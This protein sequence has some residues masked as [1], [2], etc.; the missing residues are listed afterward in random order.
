MGAVQVLSIS[1]I[2]YFISE[3]KLSFVYVS[4]HLL[5][6]KDW[7]MCSVSVCPTQDT[8]LFLKAWLYLVLSGLYLLCWWGI[9]GSPPQYKRGPR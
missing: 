5:E 1:H 7:G 4:L 3:S 8:Q 6:S 9:P 2:Y